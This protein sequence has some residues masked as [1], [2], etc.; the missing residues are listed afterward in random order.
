MSLLPSVPWRCGLGDDISD[1]RE[2]QNKRRRRSCT[3]GGNIENRVLTRGDLPA[4]QR[5][6]WLDKVVGCIVACIRRIWMNLAKGWFN[7]TILH[8][9]INLNWVWHWSINRHGHWT[10][11]K[12][13]AISNFPLNQLRFSYTGIGRSTGT[14][15]GTFCRMVVKVS[16]FVLTPTPIAG[17][18]PM[19]PMPDPGPKLPGPKPEP[20]PPGPGPKTA[21]PVPITPPTPTDEPPPEVMIPGPLTETPPLVDTAHPGQEASIVAPEYPLP[22]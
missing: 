11:T 13:C 9:T 18:P 15:T 2:C 3:L 10:V 4:L 8:W 12:C 19:T 17:P 5:F 6:G 22:R 14:A 1:A 7:F 20:K 16:V 21:G